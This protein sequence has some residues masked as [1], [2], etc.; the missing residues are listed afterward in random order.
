MQC[1]EL[2]EYVFKNIYGFILCSVW[3]ARKSRN[4]L[5]NVYFSTRQNARSIKSMKAV[6]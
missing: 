6:G 4:T 1:T 5:A 3:H 2:L